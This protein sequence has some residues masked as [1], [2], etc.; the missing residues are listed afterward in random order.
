MLTTCITVWLTLSGLASQGPSPV[1]S[2]TVRAVGVGYPPG[3]MHGAQGRLMAR[4]AAEVAA[5]RNL[6]RKLHLGSQAR[7]PAFRYSATKYLANGSVEATVE[8]VSSVGNSRE[9]PTTWQNGLR[10]LVRIRGRP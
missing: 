6:A 7:L 5:V 10:P 8:T 9:S 4:R 3:R 1:P 2:A